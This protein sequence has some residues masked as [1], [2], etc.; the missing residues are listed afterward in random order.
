MRVD[1][2]TRGF[3]ETTAEANGRSLSQEVRRALMYYQR[4]YQQGVFDE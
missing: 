2:A 3:Y 1:E 4:A